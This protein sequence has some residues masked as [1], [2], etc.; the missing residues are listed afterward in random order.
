MPL[1]QLQPAAC[2]RRHQQNASQ[3][4]SFQHH[5]AAQGVFKSNS[6]KAGFLKK[7]YNYLRIQ[8]LDPTLSLPTRLTNRAAGYDLESSH[9]TI[10]PGRVDNNSSSLA[11]ENISLL[12][13][14]ALTVAAPLLH[15]FANT[16]VA[17]RGRED[18]SSCLHSPLLNLACLLMQIDGV[19]VGLLSSNDCL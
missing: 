17:A 11:F 13:I 2:S 12:T 1:L 8:R 10:V 3:A 18:S 19:L 9:N 5:L 6:T 4:G 16:T 14:A 7:K 15:W